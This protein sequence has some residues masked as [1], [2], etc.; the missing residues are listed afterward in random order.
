MKSKYGIGAVVLSAALVALPALSGAGKATDVLIKGARVVPVEGETLDRGDIL[1]RDGKIAALGLELEAPPG[2][3]IIDGAGLTAYP[4]FIDAYTHYGLVEIGAIA[5]T[6]DVREM[7]REN[8][9]LRVV[10]AVNPHS[11]HFRTGRVNGT[12]AALVAP[13]GGTF[14]G[15][16]ALLKMEGLTVTEMAVKEEAASAVN[17]PM[18]PRPP[19]AEQVGPRP[20][21]EVDVTSKLVEK[22]KEYLAETRRY[23]ALKRAAAA[24]PSL[25][26]PAADPKAEALGPVLEGRL[27]VILSV[28]KAK[29]IELALKFIEEENIKAVFRGCAQGYKVA[30]KLKAAGVAVIVGDLYRNPTEPEE[31]YDAPFRNVA[32]MARAGVTLCFS[33]G[34]D[35]STGKD[36]TYHAARAVAFGMDWEEAVRA[37]TINAARAFGVDDRLGSLKP[38]K[39]ADIILVDGDP[40]DIRS[41]VRRMFIDGRE[42]DLSSWWDYLRQGAERKR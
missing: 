29:D 31:G 27:P 18:S 5:S 2:A 6:S 17:F 1:I 26:A 22:I 10:W 39:D 23:H 24:D 41:E 21:V 11:V 42:V 8:P 38:G 14:P 19:S 32:E 35:P 37:L 34:T 30:D 28:E 13:S 20:Q 7:G 36:L 25:K 15:I 16:S 4:G 40:L 3:R 9:E 33:S 12:T